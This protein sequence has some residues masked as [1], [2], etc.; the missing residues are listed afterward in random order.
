M[1]K[2]KK[3]QDLPTTSQP[4]FGELIALYEKLSETYDAV[5]SIHLSSGISGTYNS[6]VSANDLVD[7]IDI[8]PFD[9]E[10]SCMAQGFLC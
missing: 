3:T 4:A 6:A 7:G 5:I 9:T 8:Y 10:T 1:K 2:S